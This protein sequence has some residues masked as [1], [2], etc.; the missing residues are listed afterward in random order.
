[1]DKESNFRAAILCS[2]NLWCNRPLGF[3]PLDEEA[4][5]W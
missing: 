3:P 2:Q 4:S 1:M 5:I